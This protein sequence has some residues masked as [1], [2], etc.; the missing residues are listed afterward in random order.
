MINTQILL[1]LISQTK[2]T[3]ETTEADEK[4]KEIIQNPN[5]IFPLFEILNTSTIEQYFKMYARVCIDNIIRNLQ[6]FD[7]DFINQIKELFIQSIISE[8]D[9]LVRNNVIHTAAFLYR[10]IQGKIEW[11]E[12]LGLTNEFLGTEDKIGIALA[13]FLELQLDSKTFLE[14]SDQQR[15]FEVVLQNLSNEN[16]EIR[17]MCAQLLIQLFSD[18]IT[19]DANAVLEL[20]L[21]CTQR[22]M[23]DIGD[24]KEVRSFTNLI[25]NIFQEPYLDKFFDD[26]NVLTA[27][28]ESFLDPLQDSNLSREIRIDLSNLITDGA[29]KLIENQPFEKLDEYLNIAIN[30]SLYL[31]Q[32]EYESRQFEYMNDFIWQIA[33][34]MENNTLFYS[35]LNKIEELMSEMSVENRL[36][37]LSILSSI[38]EG[39][40][41]F[42]IDE[43]DKLITMITQ[44][45]DCEDDEFVIGYACQLLM[46]LVDLIPVELQCVINQIVQFLSEH[47]PAARTPETL[48]YIL[49]NIEAKP[50][51]L[52]DLLSSLTELFASEED[53]EAKETIIY[54]IA[55]CFANPTLPQEEIFSQY[56]PTLIELIQSE[57]GFIPSC[58]EMFK[59]FI[60]LCPSSIE[61]D[62][63]TILQLVLTAME[64]DNIQYINAGLQ[65]IDEL[66]AFLPNASSQYLDSI[67]EHLQ[68]IKE[69]HPF[70]LETPEEGDEHHSHLFI[71]EGESYP[72]YVSLLHCYGHLLSSFPAQM[73]EIADEWLHIFRKGIDPNSQLPKPASEGL[74]YACEGIKLMGT[75]SEITLSSLGFDVTIHIKS[76]EPKIIPYFN[77]AKQIIYTSSDE[78][79]TE[80]GQ[81]FATGILSGIAGELQ[82]FLSSELSTSLDVSFQKPFFDTIFALLYAQNGQNTAVNELLISTSKT[83][84]NSTGM[85]ISTLTGEVFALLSLFLQDKEEIYRSAFVSAQNNLM[86]NTGPIATEA[87]LN[88]LSYLIKSDKGLFVQYM[89]QEP[90]EL[91]VLAERLVGGYCTRPFICDSNAAVALFATV[92]VE[93]EIEELSPE[94]LQMCI[95]N[96]PPPIDTFYLH[97]CV[98]FACYIYNRI[99]E[100]INE[101]LSNIAVHTFA[102]L[103]FFIQRIPSECL[104]ILIERLQSMDPA[105]ILQILNGNQYL[106]NRLARNLETIVQQTSSS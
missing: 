102:S 9:Q 43:I 16:S 89:S 41:A 106:F 78:L 104:V 29:V 48:I 52:P 33:S 49:S 69:Q 75:P 94:P 82:S 35:A 98:L 2:A 24:E 56:A 50:D 63:E 23:Y 12:L 86:V 46:E 92:V 28:A 37:G 62:L 5:S 25:G 7:I 66:I 60:R 1:Q 93:Y 91:L 74:L 15:L 103:P 95:E 44:L 22:A 47:F 59:R 57:E 36:V 11:P 39:S 19:M 81:N 30:F 88:T 100:V 71:E 4:L 18:E 38:C 77:L 20:L 3:S 31:V 84:L 21:Q 17:I 45:G 70:N 26:P 14:I 53:A 85:Q 101:K 51:F 80:K 99:P 10:R 40:K 34:S 76:N 32:E 87:V 58:F 13:I 55:S 79:D 6:E 90:Q 42:L 8:E 105:S 61:S 64:S 97:S 27:A 68:A 65:F 96:M 73:T 67:F 54:C 72:I 83:Y